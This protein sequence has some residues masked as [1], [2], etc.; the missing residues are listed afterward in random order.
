M[1]FEMDAFEKNGTWKLV[2]LPKDKK[3]VGCKWVFTL[4]KRMMG[5]HPQ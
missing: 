1:K 2:E 4:N 5:I 3:I